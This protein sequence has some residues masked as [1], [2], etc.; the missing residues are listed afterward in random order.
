MR[1]DQIKV[2]VLIVVAVVILGIAA[3]KLLAIAR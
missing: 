2:G 3:T 1:W